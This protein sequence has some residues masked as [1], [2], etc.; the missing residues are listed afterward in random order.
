MIGLLAKWKIWE[1]EVAVDEF[2]AVTPHIPGGTEEHHETLKVG[3]Q[4]VS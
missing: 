2:K 1:N 3:S 4:C